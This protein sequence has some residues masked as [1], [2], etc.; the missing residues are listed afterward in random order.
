M[1]MDR[2]QQLE[3]ERVPVTNQA[4]RQ[5]PREIPHSAAAGVGILLGPSPTYLST[6]SYG[7]VRKY[8]VFCPIVGSLLIPDCI[9]GHQWHQPLKQIRAQS[10]LRRI[11]AVETASRLMGGRY[12]ETRTITAWRKS[13]PAYGWCCATCSTGWIERS[14]MACSG[15][16]TTS[17]ARGS[18]ER[19]ATLRLW[20]PRSG[21]S[22]TCV[23][24]R[25][26][27]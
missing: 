6:V 12:W 8:R 14:G 23:R 2:M 20:H 3:S 9:Q 26:W 17:H 25:E 11:P 22:S 19:C 21:L 15:T 13:A 16:G 4:G 27:L 1:P 10:P 18:F 24:A 5:L 7:A